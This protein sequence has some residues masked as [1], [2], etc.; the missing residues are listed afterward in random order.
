MLV[1]HASLF[2]VGRQHIFVHTDCG[3]A[4]KAGWRLRCEGDLL[5]IGSKENAQYTKG[6]QVDHNWN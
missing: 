3:G 1:K 5:G 6:Y 2:R 4:S